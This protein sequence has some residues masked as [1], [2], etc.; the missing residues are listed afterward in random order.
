[1]Q[2]TVFIRILSWRAAGFHRQAKM[3]STEILNK[4]NILDVDHETMKMG[5][6][7]RNNYC[8]ENCTE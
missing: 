4:K 6:I 5:K 3:F 8:I 1:V 2:C 7:S